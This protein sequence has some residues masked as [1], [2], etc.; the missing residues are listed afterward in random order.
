MVTSLISLLSIFTFSLIVGLEL[1]LFLKTIK[2]VLVTFRD[3]LFSLNQF[4]IKLSSLF[5]MFSSK[6]GS[7]CEKRMFVSSAKRTK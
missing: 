3:S 1:C 6:V 2:L 4:D 7:L 5:K